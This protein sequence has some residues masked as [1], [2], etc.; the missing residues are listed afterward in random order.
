MP[1]H[2]PLQQHSCSLLAWPL[3][4]QAEGT[5]WHQHQPV[6]HSS[7]QHSSTCTENAPSY[8]KTAA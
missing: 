8:V 1:P 5:S 2:L 7:L 4:L 6:A 3:L